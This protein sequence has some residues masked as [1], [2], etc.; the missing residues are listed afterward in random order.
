M[1]KATYVV[2][3]AIA[4]GEHV[5]PIIPPV[6]GAFIECLRYAGV[7][8]VHKDDETRQVFD[9]RPPAGT[10][11]KTWSEMNAARMQSF[12]YNAESCL[13]TDKPD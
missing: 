7:V 2:R 11:S 12:G 8:N 5:L 9:I 13:S 1:A 6:D 4:T 10:D 3:V